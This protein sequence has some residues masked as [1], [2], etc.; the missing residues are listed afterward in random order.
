[1]AKRVV[2][3]LHGRRVPQDSPWA[4]AAKD[5]GDSKLGASACDEVVGDVYLYW[6]IG[7]HSFS[8][9]CSC[10]K[11]L[12][13]KKEIVQDGLCN[14][15]LEAI[16]NQTH[17]Q[18]LTPITRNYLCDLRYKRQPL[19]VAYP[20]FVILPLPNHMSHCVFSCDC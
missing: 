12:C 2:V 16:A 8:P 4:V 9:Y 13:F 10:F 6:H 15:L 11:P 17:T 1:M 18:L 3:R 14:L 7:C 20:S 19:I 5:L